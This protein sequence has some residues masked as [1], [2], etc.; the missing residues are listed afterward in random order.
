M[1][2][3]DIFYDIQRNIFSYLLLVVMVFSGF[4]VIYYTHLNR[5]A[6]IELEV[7]LTERDELDIER[8]NL[9]LE[10]NS[11]SEHSV[12]ESKAAKELGM[13]IPDAE[14]EIIITLE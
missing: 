12:I 3:L 9:M 14:S 7:L 6:T 13:K 8:R 5:Q 1:L 11:L 4:L 10:Q 2:A